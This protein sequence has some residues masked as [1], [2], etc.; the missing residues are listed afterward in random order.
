[1]SCKGD[2]EEEREGGRER[3]KEGGREREREGEGGREGGRERG[4]EGGR[5]REREKLEYSKIKS[6][7]IYKSVNIKTCQCPSVL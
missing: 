4:R 2:R 7:M 3:G 6:K 5:E 1:M